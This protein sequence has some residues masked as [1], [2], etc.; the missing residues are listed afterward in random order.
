MF[1]ASITNQ[2]N[3]MSLNRSRGNG[4]TANS[5]DAANV[6]DPNDDRDA[7][8]IMPELITA[9]EFA[10]LLNIS[11]R[12]FYRLKS[13]GRIPQPISLGGSTRWSLTQV[14]QWIAEGCP[15]PS[16]RE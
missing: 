13:I 1:D 6:P 4:V 7:N 15:I 11:E 16:S 3:L 5:I 2:R 9:P 10:K 12:S 8:R 14:R